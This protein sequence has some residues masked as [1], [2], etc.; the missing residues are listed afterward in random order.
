MMILTL[1]KQK[2]VLGINL[3]PHLEMIFQAHSKCNRH[4]EE[5][6]HFKMI[7]LFLIIQWELKTLNITL[8][9]ILQINSKGKIKVKYPLIIQTFIRDKEL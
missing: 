4:Q 8:A 7:C 6:C 5:E 9:K 3:C 2:L 1:K